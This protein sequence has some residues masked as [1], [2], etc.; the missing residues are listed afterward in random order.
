MYQVDGPPAFTAGDGVVATNGELENNEGQT[1]N[2]KVAESTAVAGA[3]PVWDVAEG[4]AEESRL[5]GQLARYG[6]QASQPPATDCD[7]CFKALIDQMTRPGQDFP[8]WDRDDHT[9]LRWYIYKQLEILAGSGRGQEFIMAAAPDQPA[10]DVDAALAAFQG[11]DS[12]VGDELLF[13]FARLFKKDV[14]LFTGDEEAAAAVRYF[15]GGKGGTVYGR[16]H[17]L[18]LGRSRVGSGVERK[19]HIYSSLVLNGDTDMESLINSL[20]ALT[21]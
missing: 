3:D 17:P 10:G 9:F 18:L 20:K 6:L 1:E 8:A 2:S 12:Y 14:V 21:A 5:T 15:K 11:E 16:G 7:S 19:R 4:A 13:S